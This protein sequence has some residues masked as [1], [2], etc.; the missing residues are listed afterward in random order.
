ME[1]EGRSHEILIPCECC[2]DIFPSAI[3]HLGN[4]HRQVDGSLPHCWPAFSTVWTVDFGSLFQSYHMNGLIPVT[5]GS[6]DLV[7]NLSPTSFAV[8]GLLK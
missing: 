7:Y 8:L 1:Q 3:L 4:W 2:V 6:L 5:F